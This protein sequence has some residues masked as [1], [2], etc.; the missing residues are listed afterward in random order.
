MPEFHCE[1]AWTGDAFERDVLIREA[2]G[3]IDEVHVG[4]PS[5]ASSTR[6]SGVVFPG[7]QNSHSHVFHRL[8]RGSVSGGPGDFWSWRR[9]MYE[10]AARLD[11]DSYREVATLVFKEMV[12]AGFTSVTEFHYL[13]HQPDGRPYDDPNVMADAL[14]EAAVDTGIR[15][16]IVDTC[17]LSAGF[18]RPVEGVQRR[19][20]DGTAQAWAERVTAWSPPEGVTLGAAIHSVRAVDPAQMR[21]VAEWAGNRPLHVHVSEQQVETRE[22]LDRYGKTPVQVLADS[23][24]LGANVTLVHATHVTPDDIELV[25]RSGA[26]VCVCPSTERWLGDGVCPTDRLEEAAIPVTLGS[27]SQAVIDPFEEMRSVELHQRLAKEATGIHDPRSLVAMGTARRRIAPGES[28]DLV[29]VDSNSVRTHGVEPAGLVFAATGA[30][31]TTVVV[32]GE[33]VAG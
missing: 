21:V 30:D 22:C 20:S 14:V 27:D 28:A 9:R 32:G 25:S 2:E 33:P 19:F 6:L 12:A 16:T 23:A 31:V 24:V 3:I 13:H 10:V 26:S 29:A 5:A 1:M 18:G 11:P 17:Y 4:V 8:L 15:L 7:F